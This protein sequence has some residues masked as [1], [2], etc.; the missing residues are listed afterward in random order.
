[1]G[2]RQG[3]LFAEY[4]ELRKP[5]L[6]REGPF[7]WFHEEIYPFSVFVVARYG[8]RNDVLCV[9]KRDRASDIDAEIREPSRTIQV[10]ITSAR[11]P[12]E[13]LRMRYFVR[14]AACHLR[15]P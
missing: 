14:I 5:V 4:P 13:H 8:D 6:L 10:E 11:D 2:S 9:P 1:M 7:K 3:N 15:A 12:H